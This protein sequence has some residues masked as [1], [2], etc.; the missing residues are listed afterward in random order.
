MLGVL[1][2]AGAD[3]DVRTYLLPDAV[4]YGAVVCGVAAAAAL[5]QGASL[6]SSLS[7]LG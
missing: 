6:R 7:P 2:V 1:M 3:V 4:T 5:A